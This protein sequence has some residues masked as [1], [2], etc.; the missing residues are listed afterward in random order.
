MDYLQG[1]GN[2]K[3]SVVAYMY[4][5]YKN[6]TGQTGARVVASLLKQFLVDVDLLPNEIELVYDEHAPTFRTI[7]F[8]ALIHL[9]V[10]TLSTL[11]N[12]FVLLNGLDECSQDQYRDVILFVNELRK[13]PVKVLC[14]G[15]PHSSNRNAQINPCAI[16][17]ITACREDLGNYISE[18][19]DSEWRH[20]NEL[21]PQVFKKLIS[22]A[23][24]RKVG[25]PLC[26]GHYA[27]FI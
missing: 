23:D 18:R 20:D 16:L 21:K 2:E 14:T 1:R 10:A 22:G 17:E 24:G 9:C 15:R 7:D 6:E 11:T 3:Q 13:L 5:D 27:Y 8:A 4:F 26:L 12:A 19:L 25:F